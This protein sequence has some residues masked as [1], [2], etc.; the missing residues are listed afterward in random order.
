LPLRAVTRASQPDISADGVGTASVQFERPTQLQGLRVLVV[1]DDDDSRQLV[2][3]VLE[4]CGSV[5][6]AV[7]GVDDAL[8]ALHARVP[9]VV[10]SDIG[11]P[12]RDGYEL[13]REIRAL[14]ASHGGHL[15]AAA[16]TANAYAEDRRRVL[17]AGFTMHIAKPV[18]PAEL[19]AVVV[20]LSRYSPRGASS[21]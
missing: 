2:K 8:R 1:D 20:S 15:P 11:M 16:L 21:V 10:I 13:I 5:V 7:A 19:V 9:D 12:G 17:N 4:H 18:E 3:T 6:D 14:P